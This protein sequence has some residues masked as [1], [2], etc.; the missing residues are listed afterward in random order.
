MYDSQVKKNYEE[1]SPELGSGEMVF[2]A[3]KD[4]KCGD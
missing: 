1:E 3:G 2:D 4:R